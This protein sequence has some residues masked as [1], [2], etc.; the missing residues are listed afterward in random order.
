[1]CLVP[2]V[3]V[4][5]PRAYRITDS[6]QVTALF[7]RFIPREP[8]CVVPRILIHTLRA[9]PWLP[10][11]KGEDGQQ[12]WLQ[13][14]RMTGAHASVACVLDKDGDWCPSWKAHAS[15][16]HANISHSLS[17]FASTDGYSNGETSLG[18]KPTTNKHTSSFASSQQKS[19]CSGLSL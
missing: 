13:L 18:N 12:D 1:M 17:S 3:K 6:L 4:R 7:N 10:C 8:D 5:E 15:G 9:E 14:E 2:I 11:A 19:G 16:G